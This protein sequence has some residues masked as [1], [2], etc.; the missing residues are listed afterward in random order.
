MP[1]SLRMLLLHPIRSSLRATVPQPM[2]SQVSA[3]VCYD[4]PYDNVVP[5]AHHF[6]SRCLEEGWSTSVY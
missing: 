6:F 4:N 5:M 1:A 3:V 2:L